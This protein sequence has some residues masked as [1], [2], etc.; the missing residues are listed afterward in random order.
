MKACFLVVWTLAAGLFAI[1]AAAVE[2][3]P[4]A[5]PI[6]AVSLAGF[7]GKPLALAELK[8]KIAVVN[9]WATWCAPCRTEIPALEE[10]YKKYG[11]RGVAFVGA[12]VEDDAESVRD[13]AKANGITY[14][15][16]LAGK[17]KGIA[18]L[19][20]LGNKI[21]GLPYTVVLDRQ[22]NVFAVK[23]G[24]LTPQRLQQILESML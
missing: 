9:F 17:E 23:R 13:F 16:A 3:L 2:A 24:I 19:Q 21:A 20:A 4:S 18:L 6:F 8:G 5:E 10:G 15:V 11:P 7:D 14:P 1:P 12:A 22:G